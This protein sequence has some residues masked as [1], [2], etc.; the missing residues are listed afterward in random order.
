MDEN[1][2]ENRFD[3]MCYKGSLNLLNQWES[4]FINYNTNQNK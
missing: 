2:M 1:R 4:E 3:D